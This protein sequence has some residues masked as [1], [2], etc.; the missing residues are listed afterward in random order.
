MEGDRHQRYGSKTPVETPVSEIVGGRSDPEM[1]LDK[2]QRLE[3]FRSS[4]PKDRRELI[5]KYEMTLRMTADDKL[6]ESV[7]KTLEILWP[8]YLAGILR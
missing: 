2:L 3:T 7:K 5:F 6:R 4:S 1:T 8:E